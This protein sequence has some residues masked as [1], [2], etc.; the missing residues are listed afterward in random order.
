MNEHENE[1]A[2]EKATPVNADVAI[3]EANNDSIDSEGAVA[4]LG[5]PPLAKIF[6]G[7]LA[8]IATAMLWVG[9]G[10]VKQQA[11]IAQATAKYPDSQGQYGK[12][13]SDLRKK[14]AINCSATPF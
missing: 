4:P 8:V 1:Q 9:A 2:P 3:N 7:V 6:Y 5:S 11:C 13:N 12:L 14:A 10:G